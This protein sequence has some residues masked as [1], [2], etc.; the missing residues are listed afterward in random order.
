M[1]DKYAA[2]AAHR[3]LFP[4]TLMCR[5]LDVSCAG[6]YAAQRRVPS[7]RAQTE[8]R[9][10]VE[11]RAAFRQS[12]QRFGAPRIM[13]AL[14]QQSIQVSTKRIARLMQADGLYGR[15][16][17]RFVLTTQRDPAHRV[18]PH[19][20]QRDFAVRPTRPLNTVWVR[21]VT[22][23]PTRMG[24]LYL[25]IVLDLA[26]RRVVGWATSAR[27]D[28]ALVEDALH[29]AL[30]LRAP[31]PG[32]WHHSDQGSSYTSDAYQR[33]IAEAH[34]IPSMSR[35]ANCWDNAVAESFFATLE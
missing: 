11:V 23:L 29:R 28:T 9:L 35:R 10:R 25:A 7:A 19:L 26:S 2:I 27:N 15:P 20:L 8:E 1:S 22:F 16:A 31:P 32:W 17:R 5:V 6:F 12:R 4:V 13:R 21:D 30:A 3:A 18:A 14:R 24:W 33:T 34:G